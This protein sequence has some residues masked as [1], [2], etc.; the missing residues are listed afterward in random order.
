[1]RAW[2]R[3]RRLVQG[4]TVLLVILIIAA[5]ASETNAAIRRLSLPDCI[6]I[7][8]EHNLD[9]KIVRC[10]VELR[11]IALSG[12]YGAYEPTLNI[13]GAHNYSALP[14][15]IDEQ[16]RPYPGTTSD[17]DAY[18]ASIAELLPLGLRFSLNGDIQRVVGSDSSGA[19]ANAS[20]TAS[21]KM[22]Q[23]LL[24]DFWI[25]ASRLAIRLS[26][27]D[28]AISELSLREQIMNLVT[29]VET[30]YY[31]LL[32]AQERIQI[33]QEALDRAQK[34]VND[35]KKRVE[36]GTQ[37]RQD[38]K[39]A[40]SELSARQADLL[41]AQGALVIQ[42]YAIKRLMSDNFNEWENVTLEVI[43]TLEA[44]LEP[45]SLAESWRKGL[46]QRPDL[47]QMKVGLER[48]GIVL[49]YLNNQRYPQ[50]DLVGSYGQAGTGSTYED[51]LGGIRMGDSPFYS[52][53][54]ALTIPLAGNRAAREQYRAGKV[55]V[56]QSLLRLKQLEQDIM[57]QIGIA[58]QT[59]ETRLA[60]VDKT[61]Q[62]RLFAETALEG[63]QKK[64][65]NG[66]SSSFFI[67]Q[68]QRD[69]TSAR[70]SEAVALADYNK[71]L[72]QLALNA[73]TTLERDHVDLDIR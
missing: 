22:R 60:Q 30:G 2:S 16:N 51:A 36:A 12:T 69:L 23:P 39:Q 57:V 32:L 13:S 7:A 43:G 18:Q 47:L 66:R 50:L 41:G 38:E 44:R 73:G 34:L 29:A 9:V 6:R 28:L 70:V 37:A 17:Q 27:K 31:D 33:Q 14:G 72:A 71:A 64:F 46:I 3:C 49:K 40:E 5:R 58:V 67:V 65:E 45:L 48:Q 10:D 11:K 8:L 19:F 35:S 4:A 21:I 61:R 20:G 26:H 42:E 68:F 54:A 53:G 1:M 15:G 55:Q 56:D 24:K 63:E 62:S 52:F 59:A 25:D